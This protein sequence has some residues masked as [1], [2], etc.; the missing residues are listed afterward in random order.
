MNNARL[1]VEDE[2]FSLASEILR[3]FPNKAIHECNFAMERAEFM[4]DDDFTYSLPE[5]LKYLERKGLAEILSDDWAF[6]ASSYWTYIGMNWQS[7]YKPMPGEE[8]KLGYSNSL[9]LHNI[10]VRGFYAI[11]FNV[12]SLQAWY[13]KQLSKRVP[14]PNLP[15]ERKP[16]NWS[17]LDAEEYVV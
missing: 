2:V 8:R 9:R 16:D 6:I 13:D 10:N 17:W 12:S 15:F 5:T 3:R 14:V 4:N 11:S 1:K 7:V